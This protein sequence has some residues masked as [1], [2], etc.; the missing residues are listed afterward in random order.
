[1]ETNTSHYR[2]TAHLINSAQNARLLNLIGLLA[3][4]LIRVPDSSLQVVLVLILLLLH[5]YPTYLYVRLSFD[6]KILLDLADNKLNTEQFDQVLIDLKL[7]SDKTNRS[8]IERCRACLKLFRLQILAETVI[9]CFS[10][11]ILYFSIFR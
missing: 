10:L 3:V 4:I 2:V 7:R 1:M 5:L 8:A 6:H 9:F 11:I